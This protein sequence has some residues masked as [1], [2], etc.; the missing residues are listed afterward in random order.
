MAQ[1]NKDD[2]KK[3]PEPN[4]AGTDINKN[5]VSVE[6]RETDLGTETRLNDDGSEITEEQRQ[7]QEQERKSYEARMKY[8]SGLNNEEP[9]I[10]KSED[11]WNSAN[12]LISYGHAQLRA[13]QKGMETENWIELTEEGTRAVQAYNSKED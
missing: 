10:I 9:S 2:P 1:P 3:N 8:A 7:E 13:R 4:R 5:V 11:D 6:K 12:R